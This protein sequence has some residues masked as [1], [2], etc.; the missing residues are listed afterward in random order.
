MSDKLDLYRLSLVK[1]K[2]I[3][4][5]WDYVKNKK[6]HDFCQTYCLTPC[7]FCWDALDCY[8]CPINHNICR[9]EGLSGLIA[10]GVKKKSPEKFRKWILRM[11]KSLE[12]EI[13]LLAE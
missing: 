11:I 9:E 6:P 7:A 10:K 13:N 3:L 8:L 5:T 12:K 4:K 1:W 2:T